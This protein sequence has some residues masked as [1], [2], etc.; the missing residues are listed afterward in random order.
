MLGLANGL[1]GRERPASASAS[2]FNEAATSFGSSEPLVGEG[3][4]GVE[5]G[6]A[7][8]AGRA[9]A[10]VVAGALTNVVA[11]AWTNVVAGAP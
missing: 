8:V 1:V 5:G 7:N 10:K 11:G 3:A 9:R 4:S 6:P 2:N